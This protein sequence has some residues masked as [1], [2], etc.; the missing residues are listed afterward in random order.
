[1]T[2]PA[3]TMSADYQACIVCG[4]QFK[5]TDV[6]I[7]TA[8]KDVDYSAFGTAGGYVND[9]NVKCPRNFLRL[10]GTLGEKGT[11]HDAFDHYHLTI[12]FNPF[13]RKFFVWCLN[14]SLPQ[15]EFD[16]KEVNFKK[17]SIPYRR[18]LSWRSRYCMQANASMLVGKDLQNL[19]QLTKFS[20]ASR[21]L[22]SESR[23]H[24]R[25]IQS[26]SDSS[27]QVK[28]ESRLGSG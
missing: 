19:R 8:R 4:A 17:S 13:Q 26:D 23:K 6:H 20:E 7:V 11:C 21:S 15:H 9:L 3:K 24:K 27:T 28:K 25:D 22:K 14:R 1:M 5:L 2:T 18:L 10:C 12:V 16:G